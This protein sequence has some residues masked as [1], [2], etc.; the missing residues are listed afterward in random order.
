MIMRALRKTFLLSNNLLDVTLFLLYL[1]MIKQHF[2]NLNYYFMK[3]KT[4]LVC[5]LAV[6]LS[7]TSCKKE[8][9]AEKFVG[10]YNGTFT[11]ELTISVPLMEE[12]LEID[13]EAEEGL[14]FTI[15]Q[16]GET[17]NVNVTFPLEG[18]LDMED[19]EYFDGIELPQFFVLNGTCDEL[20][21]HLNEFTFNQTFNTEEVVATIDFKISI[22][23]ETIEA[24]NPV[25]SW[26]SEL[27]GT[28]VITLLPMIEGMPEITVEAIVTGSF[29]VNATKQ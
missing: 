3:I 29:K 20:G 13:G 14:I 16:V 7:L 21:L 27:S 5:F 11:P 19:V 12:S 6:T 10:N 23:N 28:M 26:T 4:L 17:Q 9:Y 18:I 8:N 24:P 22:A 2:N 15:D 25:I 1:P